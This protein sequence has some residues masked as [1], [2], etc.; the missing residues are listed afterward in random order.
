MLWVA[1]PF[2]SVSFS[3]IAFNISYTFSGE[4]SLNDSFAPSLIRIDFTSALLIP[5]RPKNS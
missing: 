2:L 4:I 1:L 5:Y 3:G